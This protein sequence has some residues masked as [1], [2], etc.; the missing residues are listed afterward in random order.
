M[1]AV[2]GQSADNVRARGASAARR[3]RLAA[4]LAAVVLAG[5]PVGATSEPIEAPDRLYS[6]RFVLLFPREADR[7]AIR[8]LADRLEQAS[9]S[10]ERRLLSAAGGRLTVH[11]HPDD[12]F[13]ARTGSP[14]WAGGL[15]DGSI[16]LPMGAAVAATDRSLKHEV[17][18]AVVHRL[19]GGHAPAWLDEGL[20]LCLEGGG[21]GVWSEVLARH[22]GAIAPLASLHGSFLGLAPGPARVAYAE[23]YAATLAL[24][25]RHGL[26]GVRRLLA[27]LAGE[28]DVSRA[29][30]RALGERYEDFDAAWRAEGPG[31]L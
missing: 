6:A 16:H 27:A 30:E 9:R 7:T 13:P 29:F 1:S 12:L 4:A 28:P 8:R 3:A 11:V 10:V 25:R 5:W 24:I 19:S 17:A 21:T 23:S 14:G 26:S 20:A 31:G 2:T 22:G 15:F 18:H